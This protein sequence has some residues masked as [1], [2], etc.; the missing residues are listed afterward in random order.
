MEKLMSGSHPGETVAVTV[1]D[2]RKFSVMKISKKL[3]NK[4][5]M[6]AVREK[7]IE[8]DAYEM[9]VGANYLKEDD[10]DFIQMKG[11]IQATTN[12]S[13][14]ELEELLAECEWSAE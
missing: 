12:I 6:A 8:L 7:L 11:L 2:P 13:G 4:G 1:P 14:D 3:R 9:F 5:L 10:P